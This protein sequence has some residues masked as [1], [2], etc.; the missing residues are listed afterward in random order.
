MTIRKR[1]LTIIFILFCIFLSGCLERKSTPEKMYE[2]MEQVVSAEIPF[3]AKQE[4]IVNAEKKEKEIYDKIITLGLKQYDEIV[5]LSNEALFLVEE[6][7]ALMAEESAS[8]AKSKEQFEQLLPFIDKLENSDLQTEAKRMYEVMSERYALHEELEL[9]YTKALDLDEK[10][11][12]MFKNKDI[13]IDQ[14]EN[15]IHLI[16]D[17]YTEIYKINENFNKSTAKYNELKL[18]FYEKAGLKIENKK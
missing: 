10:L 17:T 1:I 14:L 6:R 4:P 9:S 8:I 11:Y 3:E 16:N 15:Q 13:A 5:K 18:S 12:T 2:V 7:R